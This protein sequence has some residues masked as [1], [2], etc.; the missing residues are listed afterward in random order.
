M[1][2]LLYNV[3]LTLGFIFVLPFVP[4]LLMLGS[5][6]RD[7]FSQRLGFYPKSARA[8]AGARPVWVHAA[9]VGEVRSAAPLV[10]K[11]KAGGPERKV[12]MSTFTATGQ[13]IARQIPGVDAVIFLPL[14]LFWPVRRALRGFNPAALVII[15]TEIW[16]NL[17]HQAFCRGIPTLLLSGRLSERALAR[18]RLCRPLFR[19]VLDCFTILGMQ[20]AGDADRIR[21]LGADACK[22]SV[23]G[24]LKF[25]WAGEPITGNGLIREHGRQLLV[26]GSCHRG[27]EEILLKALASARARFPRLSMVLAPRHPER[28]TEVERLLKNSAFEFHRKSQASGDQLFAKD[29]LLLDTVGELPEFFAAGDIAFVG[30]SLVNAGGHNVLEPAR[31]RKPILFG[32]YMGNFANIAAEMKKKGAAIEVDNAD[33]LAS[34]L[35]NLLADSDK[36]HRMGES[37]A[38]ISRANNDAFSRNFDIAEKYL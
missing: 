15:E 34:V 11:V 27:E 24:S 38:Q 20:T 1:W 22:I 2:F 37:A 14:D 32:P 31:Y 9:S 35:I 12:V 3:L 16:P 19:A 21:Q 4:L 33:D 30:G 18:Y 8:L 26:A 5:R 25:A 10:A 6:Y 28:F 17:V 23:V 7:G 29:V 13:R 36:R